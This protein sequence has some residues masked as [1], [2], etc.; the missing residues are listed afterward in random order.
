MSK[1]A[2]LTMFFIVHLSRY[3]YIY[4]VKMIEATSAGHWEPIIVGFLVE[5]C[6]VWIFLKGLSAFPEKD[7]VDICKMA[8]GTWIARLLLIP[9]LVFLFLNLNITHSYEM[10]SISIFLLPKTPTY[11]ILL[12][13]V[14]PL[15]I[16]WKG[17]EAISR[18]GIVVFICVLPMVIFSL[19]SAMSN[20][21]FDNLYPIYETRLSF[22]KRPMFYSAFFAHS[23]FLFL[24]WVK[25]KRQFS[26][27]QAAP[28]LGIL[29]IFAIS[30]V[31][32][33]MLIFGQ[34]S[35]IYF[36]YPN[37][38][39]SDTVDTEWVV[40]DW[41]PTFFVIAMIAISMVEMAVTFW[42]MATLIE[43]LF[44]KKKRGIAVLLVGVLSYSFSCYLD[45]IDTLA[46]FSVLNTFLC[47]Y[48]IIGIPL[49]II[50]MSLRYR[51]N[52]A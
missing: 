7:I 4:P 37:V 23:G 20:F 27:R 16:A 2:L 44:L 17:Y 21:D 32:V 15:Y 52:P 1:R 3:F 31:Y 47:F 26:F 11:F 5:L 9:L 33:P 38:L 42:M 19:I 6:C 51:R 34:E 12:L 41:L 36:R 35:I 28:I 8:S 25:M 22:F 43:K 13:Y 10:E 24:G 48:S 50:L 40:F 39:T 30:S 46:K 49:A 29:L 45:N 14:I 18:G